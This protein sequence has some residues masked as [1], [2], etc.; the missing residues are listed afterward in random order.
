MS[1]NALGLIETRGMIAAIAVSDAAVKTASVTV[2]AVEATDGGLI[3]IRIIGA[4]ADVQAAVEAGRT[5]AQELGHL[6]A[7]RVIARP[8]E[9]LNQIFNL[10]GS[11]NRITRPTRKY[12]PPS[13]PAAPRQAAAPRQVDAP[14]QPIT[15]RTVA[16]PQ[17]VVEPQPV[18]ASQSPGS[19]PPVWDDLESMPV[20]RL[21]QYARTVQGLPIQGRQIS[22]ANKTQL[23]DAIR[24]AFNSV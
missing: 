17:P 21:R 18:A 22:M 10:Y 11:E 24:S 13:K 9:E 2:A 14:P 19:T 7:S 4:L 6:H 5:V 20:V 8:A 1:H 3:T 16:E 23:L 12:P 15:T